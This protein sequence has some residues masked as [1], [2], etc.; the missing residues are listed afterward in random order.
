M[1]WSPDA[2]PNRITPRVL[3]YLVEERYPDAQCISLVQDNLNTHTA[4]A[5]YEAFPPKQAR[6]ILASLEIYYTPKHGSLINQTEIEISI[7]ERGCLSRPV[8]DIATLEQRVTALEAERNEQHATIDW[9][10]TNC[11]A[12][13]TLKKLYLALPA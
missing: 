1:S 3:R 12:R 6:H 10:F 5:L 7:F 11:Q 9:Q 2:E 8:S 4:G 13:V